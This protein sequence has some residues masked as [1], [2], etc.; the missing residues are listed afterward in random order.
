MNQQQAIAT[1]PEF[2]GSYRTLVDIYQA[3]GDWDRMLEAFRQAQI[4]ASANFN[5][6]PLMAAAALYLC[7]TVPLA[8]VV[9]RMQERQS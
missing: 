7:V 1:D 6:T 4:D 9:D 5:Y 3:Q 2:E 8:R